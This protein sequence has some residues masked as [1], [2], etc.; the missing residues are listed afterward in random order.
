M[1]LMRRVCYAD[2]LTV[3][4]VIKREPEDNYIHRSTLH[5]EAIQ[6][7]FRV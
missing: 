5:E 2:N 7:E 3:T 4:F 6:E 1:D